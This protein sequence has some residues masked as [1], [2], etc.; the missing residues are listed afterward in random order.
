LKRITGGPPVSRPSGG[1][2]I[3]LLRM[4]GKYI[5]DEHLV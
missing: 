2:G 3:C 4:P 5:L 1:R